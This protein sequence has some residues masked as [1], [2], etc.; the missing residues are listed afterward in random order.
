MDD[1]RDGFGVGAPLVVCAETEGFTASDGD[2]DDRDPAV[3]PG[4]VETCNGI[5]DDCN[6]LIDAQDPQ[7]QGL[8]LLFEDLDGDGFGSA[9]R[10][11]G[12]SGDSGLVDASGD[13][14][15]SD[16]GVHPDATEVCDGVDNDCD[17]RTDDADDSL[18]DEGAVELWS[19]IDGDGFGDP[20]LAAFG[21]APGAGMVLDSSDCDDTDPA[22]NPAAHELCGDGVDNN[23]DGS[24]APCPAYAGSIDRSGWLKSN[25]NAL[26][27]WEGGGDVDGDG[28]REAVVGTERG[29][30]VLSGSLTAS[31]G[32]RLDVAVA[33]GLVVAD[34]SGDGIDDVAVR[35]DGD[36]AFVWHGPLTG[37]LAVGDA[38][39]ILGELSEGG[40]A[41]YRD[42][43]SVG[44]VT[45]DGTVDLLV[46]D[47]GSPGLMV[48]AGPLGGSAAVARIECRLARSSS[49]AVLTDVTGD[50]VDD[51]VAGTSSSDFG[52]AY[53]GVV[54]VFDGTGVSGSVELE[55]A[56]TVVV[57]EY[58][59]AF[60]NGVEH[61]DVNGDGY[62]DLVLLGS[63]PVTHDVAWRVFH[64]P[65]VAGAFGESNNDGTIEVAGGFW[66]ESPWIPGDLNGDGAAE[67]FL[68]VQT[69]K[70]DPRVQW[71]YLF[72]GPVTGVVTELQA[73]AWQSGSQAFLHTERVGRVGDITGDGLDDALSACLD[74]GRS[75]LCLMEGGGW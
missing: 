25:V 43:L 10:I 2:C 74:G 50:G 33:G 31:V 8:R 73:D 30:E 6:D 12:C 9:T 70:S 68:P 52:A 27:F 42:V 59:T 60:S 23:C 5:D 57:S 1:D 47:A 61:G 72:H 69:D 58:Y 71:A 22:V 66:W 32:V 65:L 40:A 34:L 16:H 20:A 4:A 75:V 46:T 7:A 21:C 63:Q 14:D 28:V 44:D 48:Y 29:V 18:S 35:G 11:A 56:R 36:S 15:D 41:P 24:P 45:G 64:G 37:V 49:Q 19:D 3:H 55:D 26:D 67:L 62:E 17:G 39:V 13:C 54:A 38:D 51:V 53:E